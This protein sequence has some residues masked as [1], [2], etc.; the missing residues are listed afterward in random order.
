MQISIHSKANE[1]SWVEKRPKLSFFPYEMLAELKAIFNRS[2][3]VINTKCW[4]YSRLGLEK[5]WLL[6]RSLQNAAQTF[7]PLYFFSMQM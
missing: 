1:I 7:F 4:K 5:D 6:L 3:Y 2:M